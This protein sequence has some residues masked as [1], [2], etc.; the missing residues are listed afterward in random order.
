MMVHLDNPNVPDAQRTNIRS[1]HE[2]K[3]LETSQGELLLLHV[4][5]TGSN[6]NYEELRN[7]LSMPIRTFIAPR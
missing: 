3:P 7:D 5:W 1:I 4:S 6:D 2:F